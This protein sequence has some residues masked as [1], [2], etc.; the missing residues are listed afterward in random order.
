MITTTPGARKGLAVHLISWL[1]IGVV[2]GWLVVYTALRLGADN[3]SQAA[4][5]ALV[6]G[7]LAG[8]VIAALGVAWAR[9]RA[10]AGRPIV[11]RVRITDSSQLSTRDRDLVRLVGPTM[12]GAAAIAGVVAVLIGAHWLGLH[13]ARPKS[14]LLMIIWDVVLALW[15]LD[16]GL[17]VR[18][19]VLEG[20]E[21][22]YFGCLLT[23]VLASIGIAR[24]YV[25]GGQVVLIVAAGI[26]A[27]AIGVLTWRLSGARFVPVGAIAAIVVAGL[28]LIVPLVS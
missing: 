16:E 5:P 24:N 23:C 21:A 14:A 15:L 10:A 19:L 25:A 2:L 3:P 7:G 4:L 22:L 13:G 6:S 17:R 11:H 20:I 28:S 1:V 8:I 9:R 12:L 27:A 26:A 18:A